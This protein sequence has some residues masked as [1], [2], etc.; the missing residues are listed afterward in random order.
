MVYDELRNSPQGSIDEIKVAILSFN[1]LLQTEPIHLDP[2][3]IR[4]ARIFPIRYPSGTVV[5]G[6]MDVEFAIGDRD[7][8]KTSFQDRINLLDF[9]LED[10]RR[11]KPFFEWV[12][13]QNRYLSNSVKERTSISRIRGVRSHHAIVT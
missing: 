4:K 12:S 13:L 7:K 10:V 9:D 6:S 8:L 5:L 2:E 11:L 1:G 3:P